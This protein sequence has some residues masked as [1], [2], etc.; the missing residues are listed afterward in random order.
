M[1]ITNVLFFMNLL[2]GIG[3]SIL[4]PLFP[5][6]GTK[7]GLTESLVG[8]VIGIFSLSSTCIAPFTPLLIKKFNRIN[9]LYFSTFFEATCTLLYSFISFI[10]S[11]YVILIYMFIIR[12]IHGCCCGIIGTLIYSLTISLSKRSELKKALGYLEIGWCI[13]IIIGPIFASIFYKLG[14]YPLPFLIIGLLLYISVFLT[15]KVSQEKTESNEKTEEDPPL[16]KF[17]TYGEILFILGIFFFGYISESFYYPCLTNH[18]EKNFGLSVS[19]SSLFFVIIATSNVI[20]LQCLDK[21]TK[22]FGLYGTSCIGLIIV[23]LGVLMIYPYPPIPKKIIFIII[24]FILI[25]CGDVPIF[26]PGLV[27]LNKNIKRIDPNIDNLMANDITSAINFVIINIADFCGP[28]I[29]GFLSTHLGFKSCCLIISCILL[30]YCFLYFI[31]FYKYIFDDFQKKGRRESSFDVDMKT[32][33]NEL[34]NHPGTFK[35]NNI[36]DI[37]S[38]NE[39]YE[40]IIRRKNIY[41]GILKKEEKNE[42]EYFNLDDKKG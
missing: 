10:N 4:S 22:K 19:I 37:L 40:N 2:S 23:S 36:N 30:L 41:S 24:G 15:T 31:Y 29:G 1:K 35:D 18:L 21:T 7:N 27:A 20:I 26:I 9:L 5:S 6:I 12:I 13:G 25:G 16:L 3:F 8:W 32:D 34:I 28:I 39:D 14:G 33:E 38:S 11:F 42:Q 17:F